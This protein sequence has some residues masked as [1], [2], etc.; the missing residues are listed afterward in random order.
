MVVVEG[1]GEKSLVLLT[2]TSH[3][4]HAIMKNYLSRWKIEETIRFMKQAYDLENIRLLTYKRLQ[5]MFSL[6]MA[7]YLST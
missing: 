7:V 3:Q 2:N 6:L 5:N 4:P 1:F